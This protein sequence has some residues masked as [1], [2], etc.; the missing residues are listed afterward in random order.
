MR[1]PSSDMKVLK[2]ARDNDNTALINPAKSS[3]GCRKIISKFSNYDAR[4]ARGWRAIV[5]LR[6]NRPSYEARMQ[7]AASG[8]CAPRER[9]GGSECD[10]FRMEKGEMLYTYFFFRESH[11]TET[12][13]TLRRRKE[14]ASYPSAPSSRPFRL[15][16]YSL[17]SYVYSNLAERIDGRGH[18]SC[19]PPTSPVCSPLSLLQKHRYVNSPT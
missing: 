6:Q 17:R 10:P 11:N 8:Y 2:K 13:C 9:R 16:V 19:H 4:S 12:I 3:A 1:T 14:C 18:R 15:T 5:A 7:P